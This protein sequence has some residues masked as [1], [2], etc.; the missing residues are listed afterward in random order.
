MD[1]LERKYLDLMR[2]K[3]LERFS[4]PVVMEL[5]EEEDQ[6]IIED[7]LR[8]HFTHIGTTDSLG[9]DEFLEIQKT[10]EG[11]EGHV[12]IRGYDGGK[13]LYFEVTNI[14]PDTVQATIRRLDEFYLH[15]TGKDQE[16]I[17]NQLRPFFVTRE[18]EARDIGEDYGKVYMEGEI[19]C[20]NVQVVNELGL[21]ARPAALFVQ[22]SARYKSE[23]SVR[24]GNEEINGKS[25][26][27]IMMLAAAQGTKLVI[28]AQ[29]ED[30]EQAVKGLYDTIQTFVDRDSDL[31]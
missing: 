19:Y 15:V 26:L 5:S 25:I 17:A 29:G 13:A 24:K 21:H 7:H 11:L 27:G 2:E 6:S 3:G 18:A 10:A 4:A 23:I 9:I 30:A 28:K 8:E 1:K 20:I 12:L 14:N 31:A 22:E 16:E